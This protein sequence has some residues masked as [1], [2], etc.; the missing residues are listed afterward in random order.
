MP[1]VYSSQEHVRD[2]GVPTTSVYAYCSGMFVNET[3]AQKRVVPS[4]VEMEMAVLSFGAF[5]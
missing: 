1:D 5:F 3:L 4:V 2:F